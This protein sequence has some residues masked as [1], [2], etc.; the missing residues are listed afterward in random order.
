M[1]E[2]IAVS[3]CA[4]RGDLLSVAKTHIAAYGI[5]SFVLTYFV[6]CDTI[7]K[8]SNS[9]CFG[10]YCRRMNALGR[11]PVKDGWKS[12]KKC[13][14]CGYENRDAAKFCNDCGAPLAKK[15]DGN[16]TPS[17]CPACGAIPVNGATFCGV[18]GRK[19]DEVAPNSSACIECGFVNEKDSAFCGRCGAPLLG[20]NAAPASTQN[21]EPAPEANANSHAEGNGKPRGGMIAVAKTR[22]MEF[23]SKH[24]VIINSL[25]AVFAIIVL[26]V[27]LF[28]PIKLRLNVTALVPSSDWSDSASGS[29]ITEVEYI[30]VEQQFWDVFAA[31]GYINLDESDYNDVE[32]LYDLA[33]EYNNCL[34]EARAEFNDWKLEHP[35]ATEYRARNKFADILEDELSDVNI[36]ACMLAVTTE[37]YPIYDFIGEGAVA[38]IKAAH[39]NVIVTLIQNIL[40]VMLCLAVAVTAL[41][42]MIRA[43]LGMYNKR[44]DVKLFKFLGA[45]LIVSGIGV[46]S[47]MVSPLTEVNGVMFGLALFTA[48]ANLICGAAK[49]V[50]SGNGIINTVK[51]A[52][53]AL[54]LLI[55]FFALCGELVKITSVLRYEST[56]TVQY[57]TLP[58]GGVLCELISAFYLVKYGA[59]TYVELL[60]ASAA[61]G[62]IA[63]VLGVIMAAVAFA[64][65]KKSLKELTV[66]TS[67]M[68]GAFAFAIATAVIALLFAILSS[69]IGAAAQF[70]ALAVP[71]GMIIKLSVSAR[72]GVYV[73]FAFAGAAAVLCACFKPKRAQSPSVT[74]E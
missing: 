19:L 30:E 5:S 66:D 6:I 3:A 25:V 57:A 45:V 17:V 46:I 23:E 1:D 67:G 21:A 56:K 28:A 27:A 4:F 40:V 22:T 12:M 69:A 8:I 38:V 32:K 60:S 50:I 65:M 2:L 44:T 51:R 61:A 33:H 48:I 24:H 53:I 18:C 63:I 36:L 74:V 35:N 68:N 43:F 37:W 29:N 15:T 31:L 47:S 16:E 34:A 7:I 11:C 10:N 52:A 49:S 62:V 70:P 71:N 14:K 42:F 58:V 54:A 64:T 26:F 20:N 59:Y 39:T 13:D 41:V 72:A 55:A 73:S 9:I